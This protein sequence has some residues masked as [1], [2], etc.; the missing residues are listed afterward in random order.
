M[1]IN[2]IIGGAAAAPESPKAVA[3]PRTS[4]PDAEAATVS[5]GLL[6]PTS[7]ASRMG[8][9]A[10]LSVLNPPPSASMHTEA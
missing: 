8:V 2:A 1:S 5:T 3:M 10:Y 4:G 9:A 7:H 6:A